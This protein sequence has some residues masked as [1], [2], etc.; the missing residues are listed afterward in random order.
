MIAA[1]LII[2]TGVVLWVLT[3]RVRTGRRPTIRPL[4]AFD[5]LPSE[6]GRAAEAGATLHVGL[7]TGGIT[8]HQTVTSLAGLEVLEGIASTAAAYG[9]PPLVTV[10]DPTLLPLAQDVMRRACIR[11]GVPERY[12]PT[13]VRFIA[14]SPAAYAMGASDL[15]TEEKLNASVLAGWFNEEVVLLTHSA[16]KAGLFQSAATDQLRALGALY[17][18]D[19]LLAAG[20]ELFAGGAQLTQYASRLASLTVQDGLRLL[21]IL[22]VLVSAVINLV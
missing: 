9:I 3:I 13:S 6:L 18:A 22:V 5:E 8:G 14:P 11:A 12:K 4:P 20:E 1:V 2:V 16:E 15:L 19:T 21:F 10:G 17:P 7:G